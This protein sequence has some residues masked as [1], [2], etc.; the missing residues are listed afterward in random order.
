VCNHA[1]AAATRFAA[2]ATAAAA[3]DEGLTPCSHLFVYLLVRL[4]AYSRR[5]KTCL[6]FMVYGLWFMVYGLWFI[7]LLVYWFI[8]LLVYWFIGLLVYWFIGLWFMVY[9]VVVASW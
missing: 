9:G 2:A 6:W 8:G 4:E 5:L 7:G 1:A 3:D